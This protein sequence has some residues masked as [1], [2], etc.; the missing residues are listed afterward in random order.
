MVLLS[1][2]VAGAVGL[3]SA[4][5]NAAPLGN[6][7]FGSANG[8]L[9]FDGNDPALQAHLQA[10]QRWF[11]TIEVI[12]HRYDPIPGSVSKIDIR[13]QDIHGAFASSLLRLREGRYPTNATEASLTAKA[14]ELYGAHVGDTIKLAGEDVRV[15][16]T[17]ENPLR[18]ND[19][20]AL[21]APADEPAETVAV[22]VRSG[23]D[24]IRA[25]RTDTN[26]GVKGSSSPYSTD[27][28]AT[29]MAVF[30][31]MTIVL[32]LVA[33]VAAA[34]FA[35]I[36]QRRLRQLGMLATV[37]A[38]PRQVRLVMVTNGAIVGVVSAIT[39]IGLGALGFVIAS[40]HLEA[41]ANHRIDAFNI[42]WWLLLSA[43]LLAAFTATAAAWW[44]ARA[45]SKLSIMMTLS[46]R[47]PRPKSVHRSAILGVVILTAG[48]VALV[49]SHQTNAKFVISG[50]IGTVVGML[51]LS[52]L[53]I[54][55]IGAVASTT[56]ISMRLALRDLARFQ[57]RS[58]SALAA[59]S[60]ALGIPAA[61]VIILATVQNT[62]TTGNLSDKQVIIRVG[63]SGPTTNV[64]TAAQ[65]ATLQSAIDD[66]AATLA[67]SVVTPMDVALAPA[68]SKDQGNF[69]GPDAETIGTT[70]R[71]V[72]DLARR[73]D[74]HQFNGAGTMFVANDAVSQRFG[75][76]T[77]SSNADVFTTSAG[78]Y[79]WGGPMGGRE[80]PKK[81]NS[82][83]IQIIPSTSKYSSLPTTF[84]TADAV[85]RNGWET[86]RKQWLVESSAPIK[87]SQLTTLRE[88][89][90]SNG[91]TIE[92]RD[93]QRSLAQ[94][95]MGATAA[96]MLLAL[97][98]LAM[99]VGLIRSE[100]ARDIRL[101]VATGATSAAR[102]GITATT[103]GALA[104]FG[105]L[106]GTTLAYAGLLAAYA[107]HLHKLQSSIPVGYLLVT[108]IGTPVI[109]ACCGWLFPGRQPTAVT[110][111]ALD[112]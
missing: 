92:T 112:M 90:R 25:F 12:K 95:R 18:L 103:A 2:V 41:A 88:V 38:T 13:A 110:R 69:V 26:N 1:V 36:A 10:A 28:T 15:V 104:L 74:D 87:S 108:I 102:R 29:A 80:G 91:L 8:R 97:G 40:P 78:D 68:A 101:L 65:A 7:S 54:K 5:F 30:A 60:L 48:I 46:A 45:V 20:F 55:V 105:V 98:V 93:D 51:L 31:L 49:F 56:P 17:V 64:V 19:M 37:G 70:S 81:I 106:L 76:D 35:A 33:L 75:F 96:G 77:H 100:S 4:A 50:T 85:S 39:G 47:T 73:V 57:A 109:A 3:S 67:H 111:N 82:D 23:D 14:Q 27:N 21:T 107:H 99:T 63:G 42:P 53:L 16:G 43:F 71:I 62:A 66:F 32:L 89:A 61:L 22:L 44:P 72:I 83:Q 58:A 84:V 94:V 52:P 9:N 6:E 86:V 59:I 11:G 79:Y 24:H 34:S